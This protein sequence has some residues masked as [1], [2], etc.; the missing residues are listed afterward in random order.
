MAASMLDGLSQICSQ[1]LCSRSA[2][3]HRETELLKTMLWLARHV[4]WRSQERLACLEPALLQ[5]AMSLSMCQCL[6]LSHSSPFIDQ[7][8]NC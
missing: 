4:A 7:L 6:L 3:L 8:S 5:G 1:W 2:T